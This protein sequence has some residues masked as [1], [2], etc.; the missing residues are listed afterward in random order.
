MEK[1]SNQPVSAMVFIDQTM[2]KYADFDARLKEINSAMD[3]E[4]LEIRKKYAEPVTTLQQKKEEV[5]NQMQDFAVEH[6][7]L[8][9]SIKKSFKTKFGTFGFRAGKPRFSLDYG[10]SWEKITDLLKSVLPHY[11]RIA[12]EPAK[13]KLMADFNLPE[14]QKFIPAMGLSLTQ[15]ES[16][17]IDLKK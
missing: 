11:V 2:E 9:F 10:A 8:L 7:D 12:Y 3:K 15:D 4:I 1:T 13:D 6:Q 5:F 16:F 17:Y 14:V